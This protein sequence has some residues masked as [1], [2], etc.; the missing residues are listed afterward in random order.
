MNLNFCFHP[1]AKHGTIPHLRW[2]R[3]AVRQ[4]PAKLP[5][6]VRFRV[7][8]TTMLYLIATPIGNLKDFSLRAIE[9]LKS[10]DYVLCE[11]TRHSQILLRE[12]DIHVPLRSFHQF[13]EKKSE[14]GIIDDLKRGRSI[15]VVSDAGTPGICDPG[16]SLVRRCHAENIPLTAIPGPS[17]RITALSLCPFPKDRV[18]FLGFLPKKE[19]E[20]KRA[21]AEALLYPGTTIFYESPQRILDSLH[22]IPSER[23]LCVI[24]ELTKMH[25]EHRVGKPQDL[26]NYYTENPP[27]GECVLLIEPCSFNYH[28][29]SLEEHVLYLIDHFKISQSDSIKIVADIRGIPKRDVYHSIHRN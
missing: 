24:R 29:L 13:N 7:P 27:R 4:K 5:S 3:Q 22:Q 2:H 26:I 6:S 17:A 19:E 9:T 28:D 8:P 14:D 10:C 18:Q 16:E 21:L 11:D 23:N 15:G 12:Y 20:R 1:I 25:E